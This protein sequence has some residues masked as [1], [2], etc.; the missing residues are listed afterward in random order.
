MLRTKQ[1]S[2]MNSTPNAAFE[3]GIGGRSRLERHLLEFMDTFDIYLFLYDHTY[4]QRLNNLLELFTDEEFEN[5]EQT[6]SHRFTVN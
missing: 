2:K 5:F 4:R 1:T 3:F 6:H